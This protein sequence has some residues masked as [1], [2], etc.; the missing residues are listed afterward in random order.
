MVINCTLYADTQ[1]MYSHCKH[2]ERV[3]LNYCIYVCMNNISIINL[4]VT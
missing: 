4:C 1:D 3:K 2:V